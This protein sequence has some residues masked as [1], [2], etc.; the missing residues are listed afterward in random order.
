MA[1]ATA[2]AR[3]QPAPP[4]SR[5]R[6]ASQTALTP[7]ARPR[8]FSSPPAAAPGRR[9]GRTRGSCPKLAS[10]LYTSPRSLAARSRG[11]RSCTPAGCFTGRVT[12]P[13]MGPGVDPNTGLIYMRARWYDPGT[14][15][16]LSVDPVVA[17]T[18]QAYSYAG[19][20][21]TDYVDIGGLDPSSDC[22]SGSTGGPGAALP[23][24]GSFPYNSGLPGNQPN[25]L[26]GGQG[27]RDR[28][29]NRWVWDPQKGEWDVQHPDGSHTN[30]GPN[31]ELTHGANNFPRQPKAPPI[32]AP[33]PGG[34][35][36][37]ATQIIVGGGAVVG[38]IL[39]APETGGGSVIAL[40]GL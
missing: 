34:G 33:S 15:Q 24:G 29:G 17:Q 30:V 35:G 36:P 28:Y 4:R 23:T 25:R 27:F 5:A 31:G 22:S 16:F 18:G 21:P 37:S 7:A 40:L 26:R 11:S 8:R 6:P 20:N 13:P 9:V 38:A 1:P 2:R 19:D 14:G 3:R 12:T 39:L 32:P 10:G